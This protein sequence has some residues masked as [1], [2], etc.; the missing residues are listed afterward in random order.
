M[1]EVFTFTLVR[2]LFLHSILFLFFLL[3][4]FIIFLATFRPLADADGVF[5][6][7]SDL[8]ILPLIFSELLQ[9]QLAAPL[10]P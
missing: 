6:V 9:S 4:I 8:L 1:R 10:Y 3:P 7:A 2:S 5:F